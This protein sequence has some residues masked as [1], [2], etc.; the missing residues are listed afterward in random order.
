MSSGS[1]AIS[2]GRGWE[3]VAGGKLNRRISA[4][5]TKMELTG[6]VRGH[7]RVKTSADPTGT[8][9]IGTVNNC[10]GGV[11][12]WGTVLSGEE[13]FNQYFKGKLRD[14]RE[15]AAHEMYGM[16]ESAVIDFNWHQYDERFDVGREPHEPNRFGW[17]IEFD[18][19]D[20]QSVPKKRTALGRAKHEG[21]ATAVSADGRLAA[22]TGDDE[23][24]EHLYRFVTA[25]PYDPSNSRAN[26]DL[27]DD[28]TLS[29]A[30]FEADGSLCWLPLVHGQGQLTAENGF[31]D[32]GDVLIETRR[33]AKLVGATPMDRPED[34]E[35]CPATGRV[36]VVLTN[37]TKR[38]EQDTH[39]AN[40]RP[41]NKHGHIL[42]LT[43]P[44]SNGK[45]DHAA[46]TFSWNPFLLAGDPAQE[47][48]GAQYHAG[49]S[50][51][52]WLSSPDNCTFDNRGRI[53]IATDGAPKSA[54]VADGIYVCDTTGPGRALTKKFLRAPCGAEV[55]GPYF[56]PDN[57]TLFV[58]IQH[59]GEG[60]T[61]D[62]PDTR[63]PDFDPQ[64]PPRPAVI[65][66]TRQDF[67]P[68]GD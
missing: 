45:A 2:S 44:E 18:P 57:S 65:A 14:Q 48:D 15:A 39:P 35:A 23:R 28:G 4:L 46:E 67:G 10:A 29:V 32:Q 21:A 16:G 1:G 24:F 40:P 53:W 3:S 36:F 20:P 41:A 6:P 62:S 68:L 30:R 19:Y 54:D 27:L 42:E 59:P 12:P 8:T 58:S 63:W 9:V 55:C 11:T 51:H 31:H 5:K 50:A 52:G 22:H 13:N 56:T 26:L 66:I 25:R 64:L 60:S 47:A 43:P 34:V 61:C 49:T 17:V 7:R 38:E 33:A 37:N